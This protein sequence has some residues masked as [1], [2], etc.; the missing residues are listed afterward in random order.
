MGVEFQWRDHV[1]S[2]HT[3]PSPKYLWLATETVLIIDG[4][5]I[6]RS[7]GFGLTERITGRIR[8]KRRASEIVLETK[9]GLFTLVSIPYTLWI[10]G[11]VV[12]QGDLRIDR[13]F[14]FFVPVTTFALLLVYLAL[15]QN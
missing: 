12:S 13:W 11:K 2:V 5:K 3:Q 6:G 1:I 14:L 7:G 9:A 4:E 8:G 10:N 15:R